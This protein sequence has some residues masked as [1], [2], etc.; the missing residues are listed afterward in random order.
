MQQT[1]LCNIY[2]HQGREKQILSTKLNTISKYSTTMSDQGTEWTLIYHASPIKGR[3]EPIRLMFED[4]K[5]SYVS[6]GGPT[7]Y[8]PNGMMDCFRGTPEAVDA[9]LDNVSFPVFF[10]P[11]IRHCPRIGDK[12]VLINQ[13]PACIRY[14]SSQI[15]YEPKTPAECARADCIMMNALDYLSEGRRSFHPMKDTA[16]YFDQKE[17]GD[18][19]SL[20]F[21]KGRMKLW[22]HHFNKIIVMNGSISTNPI[23]GGNDLSYADFVLFHVLDATEFQ[24][25][26]E[27]YHHAWDNINL[28]LLKEYHQWIKQR[29]NLQ[30]YFASDRCHRKYICSVPY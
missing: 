9:V 12:A 24:F 11:A 29:P 1:F 22:L 2:A 7:L 5:I 14:I 8:G 10:P 18:K 27:Y 19:M 26:T 25:N 6:E 23:A 4:A 30:A 28:P 15:G 17:E 13:L 3:A 21:C 16:S 20:E